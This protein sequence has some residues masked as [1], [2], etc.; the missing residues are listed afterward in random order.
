MRKGLIVLDQISDAE[1]TDHRLPAILCLQIE[2]LWRTSNRNLREMLCMEC[3]NAAQL[4]CALC[5]DNPA[6]LHTTVG[7]D[8][9]IH[10]SPWSHTCKHRDDDV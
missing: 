2:Q 7:N 9:S 1:M 4:R 8:L 6:R 10:Y 5:H 3:E